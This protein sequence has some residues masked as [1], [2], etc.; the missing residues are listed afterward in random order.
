MTDVSV[1]QTTENGI[2]TKVEIAN[3][4]MAVTF[5]ENGDRPFTVKAFNVDQFMILPV[6]NWNEADLGRWLA[7]L[8]ELELGKGIKGFS[9][10]VYVN[11]TVERLPNP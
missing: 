10:P 5:N 4:T 7:Q 2:V 6:G 8:L 9:H 11:L 3:L 1:R